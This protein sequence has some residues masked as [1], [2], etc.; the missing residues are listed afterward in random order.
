MGS[1]PRRLR[2]FHF[3]PW[4]DQLEDA[5]SYLQ[6]LPTIDLRPRVA[7]PDDAQLLQMARLDA[8]WHG[9]NTRCFAA[10]QHPE[11]D[12]RPARVLGAKGA[13]DLAKLQRPVDEEWWLVF[14]GQKAQSLAGA[15]G[16]LL[17]LLAR[18]GVRVALYAFD[19][20]SR[21]M[22]CFRDLAPHLGILI[23][24]EAPLHAATAGMLARHCLQIHQSWVANL[25]P[26]SAPFNESPEE[27]ILFLGS[28]LGL[29]PHRQRQIDFL[30]K[31]FGDRFV[32]IHDHSVSVADRATL[33]RF[34]VS[35]CPEGR[36]FSVPAMSATHTDRPFWSG[37]LGI[38]PVSEDSKEGGRLEHL[39]KE[40][41]ILRYG[42]GDL[43]SL[44]AACEKALATGGKERRRIYE[45]FNRSETV[46]VV[47]AGALAGAGA[48]A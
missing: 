15:Y 6:R 47:L 29:T 20:A 11:L 32:A 13:L 16:R 44:E 8:D 9:E 30:A 39:A 48:N 3:N 21:T 1:S 28:K 35:V 19:E 2:I 27:R 14:D 18:K 43:K 25:L 36:K 22:P 26:G 31:R 38:V 7:N 33:S 46:G 10:M 40:N 5:A 42:H 4:A 17:P 12:F 24:D 41:L 45:H 34:K 37:C 23:H